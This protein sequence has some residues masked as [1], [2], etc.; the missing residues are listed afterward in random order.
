MCIRDRWTILLDHRDAVPSTAPFITPGT[1]PMP[2]G[3]VPILAVAGLLSNHPANREGSRRMVT[4][5]T[6]DHVT[7]VCWSKWLVACVKV[8][9]MTPRSRP[10]LPHDPTPHPEPQCRGGAAAGRRHRLGDQRPGGRAG[11]A[12]P[13]PGGG[14]A[15][16]CLP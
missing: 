9:R 7:P 3:R 10:E 16:R 6:G 15:L 4:G 8:V 5:A 13:L 14:A 1:G 2:S 12:S 11:G